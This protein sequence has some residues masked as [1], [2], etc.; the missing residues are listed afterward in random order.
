MKHFI[1]YFNG[2]KLSDRSFFSA[3][4]IFIVLI[5][6]FL[7]SGAFL[8]FSFGTG[9][10]K[11]SIQATLLGDNPREYGI[12]LREDGFHPK[13]RT[14][15]KGDMVTFKT[16]RDK[17]FWPAS[18]VHPTHGIYPELD[19]Q[20]P[21]NPSSSWSFAFLESG[22]WKYHDHL[23]PIYTGTIFVVEE[24]GFSFSNFCSGEDAEILQCF[25]DLL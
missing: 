4:H 14:V 9:E 13:E 15:Q 21:V 1:K 3:Q 20:E 2:I 22:R 23:Y 6:I 25:Q 5:I 24:D 10:Q 19:P 12:E 16:T 7:L 8:L 18:N 11:N 17:P